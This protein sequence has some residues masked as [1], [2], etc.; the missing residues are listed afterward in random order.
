M[1]EST[2]FFSHCVKR[3]WEIAPFFKVG[4][5]EVVTTIVGR[6][7]PCGSRRDKPSAD[8]P[9]EQTK[10]KSRRLCAASHQEASL[11]A[12]A[13]AGPGSFAKPCSECSL[14]TYSIPSHVEAGADDG[15][16]R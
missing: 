11:G 14:S 2:H 15:G 4:K 3:G 16:G 6:V 5:L 7:I 9:A 1:S 10:Q 8:G 13:R 12:C